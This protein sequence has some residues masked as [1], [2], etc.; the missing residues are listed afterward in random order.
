[1]HVNLRHLGKNLVDTDVT[2]DNPQWTRY[3]IDVPVEKQ[4]GRGRDGI[5][6]KLNLKTRSMIW[7]DLVEFAPKK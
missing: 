2:I 4:P 7:I 6:L 3:T 5:T 1:M